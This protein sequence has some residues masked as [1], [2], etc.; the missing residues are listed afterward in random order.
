MGD[1]KEAVSRF[2]MLRAKY[3]DS[4]LTAEI[5]WWLG[6]YYYRRNELALARRYF[7]SL[8]HDFPQSNLVPSAYYALGCAYAEENRHQ[9]AIDNLRKVIEIDK[10][11]LAGTASLAIADIYTK[12]QNLDLAISDYRDIIQHY[13]KLADSIYPRIASLYQKTNNYDEAINFYRRALTVAPS[14]EMSDIQFKIAELLQNQGKTLE[15]V[16]EYLKVTSIYSQQEGLAVKSLLR[17]AAIYEDKEEFKK[18]VD[19]YKRITLMNTEEAK[20]ARE[21][22]DWINTHI[23]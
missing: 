16:E 23:K 9:E 21:R 14:K 13:P 15:A 18:A 4:G 20:Y 12:Q 3:P 7:Y 8:I 5:I 2:K 17:V 10:S 1:E 22:I 6:G 11:D 19:I